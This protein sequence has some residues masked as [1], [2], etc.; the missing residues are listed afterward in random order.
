MSLHSISCVAGSEAEDICARGKEMQLN[1]C[2][3]FH[4]KILPTPNLAN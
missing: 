2:A 4:D 1:V 3:E